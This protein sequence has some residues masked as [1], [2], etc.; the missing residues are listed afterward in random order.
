[1]FRVLVV[2][3]SAV[4]RELLT[5]ILESDP[6]LQVVGTAN[7]GEEG[8]AAAQ[9][10]EP[11]VITM[12]INMPKLDGFEATHRIRTQWPVEQQPY[13]I[14]MTAYALMGDAERCLGWA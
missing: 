9:S 7:D 13:I 6:A 8:V 5:H 12:D 4:V 10:Q 14:A 1:M 3:D 11:D 2:E